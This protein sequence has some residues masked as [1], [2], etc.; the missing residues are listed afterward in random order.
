MIRNV[1]RRR[2]RRNGKVEESRCYYLRYRLG[3]MR[4]D[5]WV[6]LGVTD[7]TVANKKA[8]EIIREKEMEQHGILQPKIV[9]DS[10]KRPLR[11]H[12]EDYVADLE[13]R[14][15]AGRNGRGGRQI[16]MRVAALLED[17]GWVVPIDIT[18]DS[19]VAWRTKKEK[20]ARTLNHYLQA[21]LAFLNWMERM[22]RIGINP[23]KLVPKV[24]ERGRQKRVRRAFTDEELQ[25]LATNSGRRGMIYHVAGRTGLRQQELREL[26][27]DDVRLDDEVPY[28]RIRI[29]CAKNKKE[30][31]VPLIP[32]VVSIL[33]AHKLPGAK[34]SD[35]VFSSVP[36]A[37]TLRIDAERNGIAYQDE[38][39]RYADFHALRNTWGTFLARHG[40]SQ[41][42]A[43][44]L[45]RHSDIKLTTKVYT[46]EMQ[47]PAYEA[48]KQLPPLIEGTQ[49]G[50]QKPDVT[51]QNVSHEDAHRLA[52]ILAEVLGFEETGRGVSLADA[53]GQMAVREGF[54]PSVAF[55]TTEL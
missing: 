15:R 8:D 19:F 48:V 13:K 7:K 25:K 5:K 4:R 40:V 26:I 44:K 1:V 32:E 53:A 29:A 24:D 36:Q 51:G 11:E 49:I 14:N 6:S 21:M 45:L 46:D 27:W 16:K 30:E 9:R 33:R 39:G 41:R 42:I 55:W 23:L 47:L 18:T 3:S 34:A 38:F 54:E 31:T 43:M 28:V 52:A 22:G 20:S 17:C 12:L 37:R 10:A 2:R 35:L 50:A